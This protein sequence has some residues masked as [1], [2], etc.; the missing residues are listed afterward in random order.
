[1]KTI[2]LVDG[3]LDSLNSHGENLKR[4]GYDVFA[5]TGGRQALMLLRSGIIVGA[6]ITECRLTDMD[7][8]EFLSALR[9]H[10]PSTPVIVLTEHG[11]V[12]SYLQCL[13]LGV[14]EYANK[15]LRPRELERIVAAAFG[16]QR[17]DQRNAA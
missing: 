1:M 15:P 8:A 16:A 2:L 4:I 13:D 7:G 12:E 10:A 17:S 14:F 5:E 11:S 3:D 6:V 9:H